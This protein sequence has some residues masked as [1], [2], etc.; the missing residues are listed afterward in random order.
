MKYLLLLLL[1]AS[2]ATAEVMDYPTP[3]VSIVGEPD[4]HKYQVGQCFQVFDP[5]TGKSNP[6]DIVRVE[7]IDAH[8]YVYR[9][10][11]YLHNWAIDTNVGIGKFKLFESM[12][13]E[14]KC[15]K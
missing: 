4:P 8:Q 2:C 5:Q 6:Q 9:W 15:P 1:A 12:T 13:L 11:T 10:W 7:Q 14:V 3:L